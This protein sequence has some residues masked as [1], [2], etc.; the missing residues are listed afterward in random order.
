VKTAA[1]FLAMN[2]V[3]CGF[4][5]RSTGSDVSDF[6]GVCNGGSENGNNCN[7][8]A[9]ACVSGGGSCDPTPCTADAH[10]S[11][12][13]SGCGASGT[14]AC[15]RCRQRTSG[16]FGVGPANVI[17]ENGVAPNACI[18]TGVHPAR[19]A[20][21]FCVPPSFN[22]TVD[23]KDLPGPGAVTLPGTLEMLP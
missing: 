2:Q 12:F 3:F 20:S 23:A 1:D 15:D 9:T 4:C 22:T 7:T 16:A 8:G 10:C 18:G 11:A 17:T 21:V 19:L 6:R 13:T 14:N 5:G